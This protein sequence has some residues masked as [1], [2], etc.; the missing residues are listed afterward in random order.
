MAT[1]LCTTSWLPGSAFLLPFSSYSSSF[2]S[3]SASRLQPLR[4]SRT[5]LP[6]NSPSPTL[7]VSVFRFTLGIPGFDDSE[8]PRLVGIAFAAFLLLN[9]FLTGDQVTAAQ[10]RS[11]LVGFFNAILSISLPS[12][13]MSLN[14]EASIK[15]ATSMP[16]SR[17]IFVL[18]NNLLELQKEDLAWASYALLKNTK[19]TSLSIWCSELVCARG[20]WDIPMEAEGNILDWLEDS[21]NETM[22]FEC[23]TPIYLPNK[24]DD[25]AWKVVP[26]GAK[27]LLVQPF[28]ESSST[29]IID[30]EARK[31]SIIL[32]SN[33]PNAFNEKDRTWVALLAK[34]LQQVMF[35]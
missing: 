34:K 33:V 24:A 17:Q 12:I 28:K 16:A 3:C 20:F 13:G 11:E 8:L 5:D 14:G 25:R 4:A 26:K 35:K 21:F 18:A 19:T 7:D 30:H 31:G 1:V 9:H 6:D 10:M 15:G 2:H 32:L 29:R 23:E 22:L 27:C